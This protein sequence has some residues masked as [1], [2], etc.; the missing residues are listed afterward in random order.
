MN[1]SCWP[2]CLIEG[3]TRLAIAQQ[4]RHYV[5]QEVFTSTKAKPP[6]GAS[7][8]SDAERLAYS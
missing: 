4:H 1:L 7:K 2:A 6:T 3:V 8:K 5:L